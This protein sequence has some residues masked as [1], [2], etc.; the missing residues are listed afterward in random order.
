MEPRRRE[1]KAAKPRAEEK[2]K[3][4][5]LVKLEERIAPRTKGRHTQGDCTT[6]TSYSIE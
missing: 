2:P 1:L 6:G 3:R 4:F 5:R